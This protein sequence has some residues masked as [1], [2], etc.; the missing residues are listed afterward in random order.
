MS[1]ISTSICIRLLYEFMQILI[2]AIENL[3]LL[4]DYCKRALIH[5]YTYKLYVS[6]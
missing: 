6:H 2:S 4:Y 1:A 3:L 5:V